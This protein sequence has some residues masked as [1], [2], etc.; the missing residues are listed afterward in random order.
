VN[1]NAGTLLVNGTLGN[2]TVSVASGATLGGSGTIFGPV[3]VQSGATLSP[4]APIGS[5]T[6][7]NTLTLNGTTMF[8]ANLTTMAQDKIVGLTSVAYGGTLQLNLTGRPV[9]STDSFKL[10]DATTVPNPIWLYSP[11]SGA[12]SSIIP[13][14]PGPNMVWDTSTLTTDGT[15][16]IISTA[17]PKMTSSVAGSQLSLSWPPDHLGWH[18]QVQTNAFYAGITNSWFDLANTATVTNFTTPIVL[19][20]GSVFYRLVYP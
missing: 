11:Y 2:A 18:L 15:L 1:L 19:T 5:M 10:F 17:A 3:T 4:G 7:S 16:R 6:I 14:T 20:N 12:F 9:I 13:A 8:E